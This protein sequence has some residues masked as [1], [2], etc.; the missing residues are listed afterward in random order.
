MTFSFESIKKFIVTAISPINHLLLKHR[1]IFRNV[2]LPKMVMGVVIK[3]RFVAVTT[4][5]CGY[6]ASSRHQGWKPNRLGSSQV[7]YPLGHESA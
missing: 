2:V 1:Y 5:Q 6:I 4:R 7:S 3:V